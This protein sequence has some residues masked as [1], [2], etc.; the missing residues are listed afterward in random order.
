MISDSVLECT[1]ILESS[2]PGDKVLVQWEWL[3]DLLTE[4]LV[5]EAKVLRIVQDYRCELRGLE[6]KVEDHLFLEEEPERQI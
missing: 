3:D 6:I 4:I 5:N 2:L 1:R